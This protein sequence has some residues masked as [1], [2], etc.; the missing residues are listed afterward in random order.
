MI[1]L[2]PQPS[3]LVQPCLPEP[4]QTRDIEGLDF[5]SQLALLRSVVPMAD[6]NPDGTTLPP[7]GKIL[8]VVIGP[9]APD[10][11]EFEPAPI[12]KS[13]IPVM[14]ELVE[15]KAAPVMP[16]LTFRHKQSVTPMPDAVT[17]E[18]ARGG[19]DQAPPPKPED[20]ESSEVAGSPAS[21]VAGLP[22]QQTLG[23]APQPTLI[24]TAA[25]S[26]TVPDSTTVPA[27]ATTVSPSVAAESQSVKPD[28]LAAPKARHAP[29]TS[30]KV[31]G[32]TIAPNPVPASAAPDNVATQI[33]VP[34]LILLASS[35]LAQRNG[36]PRRR[37]ATPNSLPETAARM[38]PVRTGLIELPLL[39][40]ATATNA[41]PVLAQPAATLSAMASVPTSGPV[42]SPAPQDLAALID[43]IVAAREASAAP[44][45]VAV[46]HAEFGPVTLR[47]EQGES[48]LTVAATCPDPDFARAAAAAMPAERPATAE[49]P[50]R[51]GGKSPAHSEASTSSGSQSGQSRQPATAS[52]H[53]PARNRAHLPS[54]TSEA[55]DSGIFA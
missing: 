28:R 16:P 47:F 6:G 49:N 52:P 29:A 42:P 3:L 25:F 43:R 12:A 8:P 23:S 34:A 31:A 18:A 21:L 54:A 51:E 38:M 4:A 11:P 30:A 22:T 13:A 1:E 20:R 45:A 44:L 15:P 33:A 17:V 14:P 10:L 24:A 26:T 40:P 9:V 39:A 46:R 5:E 55:R 41:P 19:T 53:G 48:G 32:A 50:P 35:T 27:T 2:S 7:P 37:A 36:D